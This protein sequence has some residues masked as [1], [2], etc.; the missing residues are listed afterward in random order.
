[1]AATMGGP[2]AFNP[3]DDEKALRTVSGTPS[4]NPTEESATPV[5]PSHSLDPPDG[6]LQAWLCIA[7]C[8]LMQFVQFGLSESLHLA[9]PRAPS[10]RRILWLWHQHALVL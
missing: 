10:P 4:L 6:G 8:F 1:M 9:V 7:G 5:V 2:A 3:A